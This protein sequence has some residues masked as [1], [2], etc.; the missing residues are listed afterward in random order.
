M[1]T[2]QPVSRLRRNT[3]EHRRPH[4]RSNRSPYEGT[5]G[6]HVRMTI[7]WTVKKGPDGAPASFYRTPGISIEPQCS[8]PG[9]REEN[10]KRCYDRGSASDPM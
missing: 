6:D 1:Q 9:S 7:Q 10:K 3:S 4:Q 2:N 8:G 5:C